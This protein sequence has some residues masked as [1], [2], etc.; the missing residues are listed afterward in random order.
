M[1]LDDG[2]IGLLNIENED[3]F[4]VSNAETLLRQIYQSARKR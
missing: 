1:L 3:E 4:I 2:V